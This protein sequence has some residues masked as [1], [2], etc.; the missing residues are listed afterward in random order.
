MEGTARPGRGT[1][2]MKTHRPDDQR[3]QRTLR[4]VTLLLGGIFEEH[5]VDDDVV[6]LVGRCLHETFRDA[7]GER[8]IAHPP[9]AMHPSMAALLAF[10]EGP[11]HSDP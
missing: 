4:E 5:D 10:L 3:L 11:S 7:L 1:Y 2:R 6:E 9:R 8:R